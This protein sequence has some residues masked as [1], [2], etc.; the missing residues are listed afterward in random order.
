VENYSIRF[1]HFN[2]EVKIENPISRDSR[3]SLF[4]A[5]LKE[6]FGKK[7]YFCSPLEQN[8]NGTNPLLYESNSEIFVVLS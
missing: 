5:E 4:F 8:E 2:F 3:V 1:H 7:Y 6:I